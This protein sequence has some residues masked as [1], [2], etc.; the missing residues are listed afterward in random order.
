MGA[1]MY[2][3]LCVCLLS[4]CFEL[5]RVWV[6]KVRAFCSK[7]MAEKELNVVCVKILNGPACLPFMI[8][9]VV[10]VAC[11]RVRPRPVK[12]REESEMSLFFYALKKMGR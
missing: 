6:Q 4:Q 1:V 11:I 3:M 10:S 12:R 9:S 7:R 8:D 2:G 5:H